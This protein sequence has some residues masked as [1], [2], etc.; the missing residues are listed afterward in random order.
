MRRHHAFCSTI[1]AA[2]TFILFAPSLH[3]ADNYWTATGAPA[4]WFDGMNWSLG[5]IPGNSDRAFI[6]NTGTAQVA[7][8]TV[9]VDELI[10][11]STFSGN[12]NQT[13]GS[14][15]LN[16]L[17]INAP[18]HYVLAGGNLQINDNFDLFGLLDFANGSSQISAASG[19]VI[20]WSRGSIRNAGNVTFTGGAG[21]TLF[22]P[23]SVDP[24]TFFGNFSTQGDVFQV[25]GELLVIPPNFTM[26]ITE[27][28]P[29]RMRVEGRLLS[30]DFDLGF[31][32]GGFEVAP[33]GTFESTGQFLTVRTDSAVLGGTLAANHLRVWGNDDF[34]TKTL[35]Q[36]G[37]TV[38]LQQLTI[39]NGQRSPG[40][41]ELSGGTLSGT[42]LEV[43]PA[44]WFAQ[45]GGTS[46]FVR[47]TNTATVK[48]GGR[49]T[50][51]GG[52]STLNTLSVSSGGRLE[53]TGGTLQINNRL[54]LQA[55]ADF[56]N[57]NA[58]II[59]SE[60]AVLDW[61]T[62]TLLNT[63]NA[64]YTAGL[65]SESYFPV[66]FDPYTRFAS[67]TSQGLVHTQ[68]TTLVIPPNFTMTI[69]EERPDRMR[70][71]GRLLSS[72]FD[73]GFTKGG[74]EVA[75]G[76]TFESTGQFLTVRTDSAVLG[77][78]LAAN[79]LRVWGN[80]DFITKTLTQ[81]GGTVTLQQL[82]IGNGQRSPGKYELS[83]GTL[84]GTTLE[85]EPAG[86]F[87]QSGGTSSFVR[88]T[89]TATVKNGGR[90]TL[91]GGTST[92]NTL[93]V[94]SGGRL[95]PTGGTLQINNRL[96]LQAEADFGN[97]NAQIIGSE[98]AV[99]DWSTG[100]L[101]N[102]AN[103][104]YTAGL[105][106]ESYF[107]V[108]FDPYTR[109][110][111]FTS[112]GLVHSTGTRLLI[113]VTYSGDVQ[114][115]STNSLEVSGRIRILPGGQITAA[116]YIRVTGVLEG[117]GSVQSPAF[118]NEGTVAPG[119]GTVGVL[120]VMGPYEQRLAGKLNIQVGGLTP[121]NHDQ[122]NVTGTATLGGTME[123][124]SLNDFVPT[125][126][127]R[128]TVL[129]YGSRLGTFSS[130]TGNVQ[131]SS[132]L[133]PLYGPTSTILFATQTGDITWGLDANGSFSSG[134]NWLG[135]V[136]PN[137]PGTTAA[138]TNIISADRSVT[139]DVPVILGTLKFD[140][141]NG[142][143][144][145]GSR[146]SF[147]SGNT[148]SAQIVVLNDHGNGT[149]RI[150]APV[151]VVSDL[152]IAHN[153]TSSLIITGPFTIAPGR[154]VSKTGFG[155]V[156]LLGSRTLNSNSVLAVQAGVVAIQSTSGD[157]VA[158]ESGATAH[159]AAGATLRISGNGR[160]LSDGIDHVSVVNHGV[161]SVSGID[162]A[163][164][165]VMGSGSIAVGDGTQQSVLTSSEIVQTSLNVATNSRVTVRSGSGTSVFSS[166]LVAGAPS[167]PTAMLD[168][169]N[170]AA[171]IDYTATSPVATVRSQLVA[172]RGGV[173]LG[174]AW[175]GMGITSSAA[176]AA[177]ST[178]PESR[179]VGYAE[180]S[181]LPLG[182]YTSFH[183]QEVDETSILMAFTRTGDANLDGVVNDNDVTI[184]GATYAPGV[185][186]PHWALG[187]FD[188]NG[189]VDDD[190]VTL[191]GV[192]YDPTATPLINPVPASASAIAATPEPSTI[193]LAVLAIAAIA[194]LS[195]RRRRRSR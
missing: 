44:G 151:S 29:D 55:E 99:L 158:I 143:R 168:L 180:N 174:Q 177:N 150:E 95:E 121:A 58:Q 124:S 53:P 52:T 126:G 122:L 40:K 140:D 17:S 70:V 100:T 24:Q 164:G 6:D 166:L 146:I 60:R 3:G 183:G 8:G 107:P 65:N 175:E 142:Y 148:E 157:N 110:A 78:T 139:L 191:L 120:S 187:D 160:A 125:V 170:N 30:S 72:D 73:L 116:D 12:L 179:S 47:G 86:W 172:G 153:T 37:G 71:E 138:L 25:S 129:N 87:A 103:A 14:I 45:S 85:V 84:S 137:G 117:H 1:L 63:A 111:S 48:N 101:L 193:L 109:F 118:I 75:P 165:P 5:N 22:L 18:S 2:A 23:A 9:L 97:G 4:S 108:G 132:T 104:R 152:R 89:N 88:G 112:Q 185:A 98:R 28:R 59:G 127:S 83:G 80:D 69:T 161:L 190:D 20:D 32:K 57:G 144:L 51:S 159:V 36:S 79:H 26:T 16:S 155:T 38:T 186:Q 19:S 82:T 77:G 10:L 34:I 182:P 50:L 66:G 46:S 49:F 119:G 149:H 189:F 33:G 42:T 141:D 169:T 163:I 105:N 145:N 68:G 74:F 181:A 194:A 178:E 67:F 102:T 61:S 136:V 96:T 64:R 171:V 115:L 27:E 188:Y 94:S 39:G 54:T 123:I 76:G 192:F 15:T 133:L 131:G 56:G 114:R 154:R 11:G 128:Y 62:G 21:S 195:Q 106:S 130:I 113:P 13:G 81:S 90:F 184:V 35:T 162:Q 167:A 135:G 93:S 31:T 176:A 7:S 91:S 43:E 173:G 92:L 41:Y 156:D 134:A 147:D